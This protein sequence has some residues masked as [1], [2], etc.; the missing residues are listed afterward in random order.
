MQLTIKLDSDTIELLR[1]IDISL[2]TL[3]LRP[4][5]DTPKPKRDPSKPKAGLERFSVSTDEAII[6]GQVLDMLRAQGVQVEEEDFEI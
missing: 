1:S 4:S 3:A 6:K 5:E 2:R